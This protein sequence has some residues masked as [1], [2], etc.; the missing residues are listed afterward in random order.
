M[1]SDSTLQLTFEQLGEFSVVLKGNIHN[2]QKKILKQIPT[3]PATYVCEAEFSSLMQTRTIYFNRLN[4][5]AEMRIQL[6]SMKLDN[7]DMQKIK[8]LLLLTN[9]C[10]FENSYFYKYVTLLTCN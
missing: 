8:A 6:I 2:D 1:A 10:V 5:K 9:I 7:G 3:I 4:T